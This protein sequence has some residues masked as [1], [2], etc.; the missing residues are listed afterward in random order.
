MVFLINDDAI[1]TLYNVNIEELELGN[2]LEFVVKEGIKLFSQSLKE[3]YIFCVNEDTI[4]IYSKNV[5]AFF[6]S[7]IQ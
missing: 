1:F 5:F 7:T 4:F 3:Y 6:I 2:L